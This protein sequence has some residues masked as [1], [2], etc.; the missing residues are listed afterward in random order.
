MSKIIAWWLTSALMAAVCA[1]GASDAAS[2]HAEQTGDAAVTAPAPAPV[3]DAGSVDAADAAPAPTADAAPTAPGACASPCGDHATCAG[4]QCVAGFR[5]FV[6]STTYDGNLGG[7]DGAAA[8]CQAVA[9]A[10]GLGGTWAAWISASGHSG[11]TQSFDLR[12]EE[13][14]SELQ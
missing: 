13:H 4:S 12:S 3:A 14:T 5:V 11:K 2:I 9:T 7:F 10:A 6:S 8:K 1:C